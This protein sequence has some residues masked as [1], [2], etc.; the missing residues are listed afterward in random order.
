MAS[1]NH[2]GLRY[3]ALPVSESTL[4]VETFASFE[5]ELAQRRRA[6]LYFFDAEGASGGATGTSS[7]SWSISTTRPPRGREVEE[8]GPLTP[9][10]LKSASRRHFSTQGRASRAT[11]EVKPSQASVEKPLNESQILENQSLVSYRETALTTVA[12]IAVRRRRPPPDRA[13]RRMENGIVHF[14]GFGRSS[15]VLEGFINRARRAIARA[16]LPAPR[17]NIQAPSSFVG[18]LNFKVRACKAILGPPSRAINRDFAPYFE[19]PTIGKPQS[20]LHAKLCPRPV[21]G[22][23]SRQ[24]GFTSSFKDAIA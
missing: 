22:I 3:V 8:I 4:S 12:P 17:P 18:C 2:Q 10:F 9:S 23:S 19:S 20:Q 16:S 13:S 14:D 24:A 7:E 15:G 1:V 5:A 6:P 11:P 21:R